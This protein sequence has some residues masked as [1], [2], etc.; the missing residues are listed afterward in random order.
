MYNPQNVKLLNKVLTD[1]SGMAE[2][3]AEKDR[4]ALLKDLDIVPQLQGYL[5]V[6]RYSTK[7]VI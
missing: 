2:I 6:T 1:R 3:L 4:F 5:G 7:M